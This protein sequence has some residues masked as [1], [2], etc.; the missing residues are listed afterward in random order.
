MDDGCRINL[1]NQSFV[2]KAIRCIFS[3]SF[4]DAIARRKMV[5]ALTLVVC[6]VCVVARRNY[7][8]LK[9]Q[10]AFKPDTIN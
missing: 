10:L 2:K 9:P 7:V 4:S 6:F 5:V 1:Y 8:R 3:A